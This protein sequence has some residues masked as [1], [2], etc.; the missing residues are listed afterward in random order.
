MVVGKP[1]IIT[2]CC[3]SPQR[4]LRFLLGAEPSD[5]GLGGGGGADEPDER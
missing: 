2:F 5:V 4:L 3:S 1:G